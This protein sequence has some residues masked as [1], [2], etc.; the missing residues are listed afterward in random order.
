[1]LTFDCGYFPSVSE[2]FGSRQRLVVNT[3]SKTSSTAATAE[4][5]VS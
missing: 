1:M 5:D 2:V 4:M 3:E